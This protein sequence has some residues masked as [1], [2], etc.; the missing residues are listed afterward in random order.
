[1][2]NLGYDEE[3]SVEIAVTTLAFANH[4]VISLLRQ[5][6]EAIKNEKWDKQRELEQQIN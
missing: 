1:M 5:R 3:E 2:P 4:E 6:G